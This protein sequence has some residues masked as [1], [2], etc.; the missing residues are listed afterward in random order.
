MNNLGRRIVFFLERLNLTP[1]ELARRCDVAPSTVK[2]WIDGGGIELRRLTTLA[3]AL[4][5][6]VAMF[7][8]PLPLEADQRLG[9]VDGLG[10]PVD[11]L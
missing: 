5:I 4:G 11:K 6:T 1:A 8:A 2:R 3:G 9:G 7:M 10:N